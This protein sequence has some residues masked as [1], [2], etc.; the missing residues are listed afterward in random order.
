[1][2]NEPP[3]ESDEKLVGHLLTLWTHQNTLLWGRL[4]S[5]GLIQAAV[6]AGWYSLFDGRKYHYAVLL[7]LL[8]AAL[9]FAVYVVVD[10]DLKWRRDIKERLAKLDSRVFPKD[11]G[12]IPGWIV[13]K[14]IALGFWYL[15]LILFAVTMITLASYHGWLNFCG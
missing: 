11:V 6:V 5:I 7:T 4:Q 9:S 2:C 13:I 10:C 3:K 15:N 8:G 12:G 14:G 1:M